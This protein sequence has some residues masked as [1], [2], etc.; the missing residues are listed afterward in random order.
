MQLLISDA[1]ILID[2][3]AGGL[4][5]LMFSLPYQFRVP[6]VILAE[7]LAE[8][9]DRLQELNVQAGE[10][11]GHGM[12]YAIELIGRH[13]KVSRYDCM[14]LALAKQEGCPLLTGD[15]ALRMAASQEAVEVKGSVWLMEQLII[16]GKLSVTGAEASMAR[17]RENGRRLPWEKIADMLRMLRETGHG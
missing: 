6:D 4:L 5:D 16:L 2:M 17:M 3:E 7:E 14:G 9:A 1:N 8:M 12:Q 15:R 10:L 11:D 13:K